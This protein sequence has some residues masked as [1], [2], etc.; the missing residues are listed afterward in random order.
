MGQPGHEE[1]HPSTILPGFRPCIHGLDRVPQNGSLDEPGD[2][3]RVQ[4]TRAILMV[5]GEKRTLSFL[6]QA[7]LKQEKVPPG[8]SLRS[9]LA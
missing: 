3:A 9:G 8:F 1:Q 5:G 2:D 7:V 6:G 4:E